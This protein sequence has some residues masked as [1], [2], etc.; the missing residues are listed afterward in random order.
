MNSEVNEFN[1]IS[2]LLNYSFFLAIEHA[3]YSY[4]FLIKLKRNLEVKLIFSGHIVAAL[5][6]I[7]DFVFDK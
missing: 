1:Y 2:S 4:W 3:P 5:I 7:G 6:A